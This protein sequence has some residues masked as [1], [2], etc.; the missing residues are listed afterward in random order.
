MAVTVEELA[1]ALRLSA[2]G[3][4]LA[5]AQT[6]ILGR[7]LGV[8][9]AHVMLMIPT[10]PHAV[11]DEAIVRMSSYLY[12]SPPGAQGT[13]YANAWANSGAGALASRW[14][15]QAASR[16]AA[17]ET[18]TS[19][20]TMEVST[21]PTIRLGIFP[22]DVP[23]GVTA[24]TLPNMTA[25]QVFDRA[26]QNEVAGVTRRQV[27]K[28]APVYCYGQDFPFTRS[29]AYTFAAVFV[30]DG[31]PVPT[32]FRLKSTVAPTVWPSRFTKAGQAVDSG[33]LFDVFWWPV[34]FQATEFPTETTFEWP[35]A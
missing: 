35:G 11:Q 30:R 29:D 14:R 26:V 5:A 18:N 34:V 21:M 32:H 19:D 6:A 20:T 22:L 15:Q 1:V 28:A 25:Q 7:L 23:G 33:A 16:S 12:D 13:G 9:E 10:A 2:D 3:T 17:A 31:E 24:V 4:G 8:A 27:S